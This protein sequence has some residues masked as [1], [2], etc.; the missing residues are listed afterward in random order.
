MYMN[1]RGVPQNDAE[2][3]KWYR[4]AAEQGETW[5]QTNLGVMFAQ[6]RGIPQDYVSAYKWFEL[7]AGRG[8][9]TA[10]TDRDIIAPQMTP[11]Q[12]DVAQ[13]MAREWKAKPERQPGGI[14]VDEPA[15]GSAL[16]RGHCS[17]AL[18]G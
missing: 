8:D 5:G 17:N 6:G 11:I 16:G 1:G 18:C 13:K 2:A 14:H 9:Q 10:V 7:A 12:I 3:V 4:R 15:S